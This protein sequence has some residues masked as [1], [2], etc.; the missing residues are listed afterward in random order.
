MQRGDDG[1]LGNGASYGDKKAPVPV[2]G[3]RAFIDM[4][5]GSYHTCALALDGSAWCWG[6]DM[7]NG[8]TYKTYSPEKV[9]GGHTFVA[10]SGGSSH[11]CAL[12]DA[13]QIWCWGEAG[14]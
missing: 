6:T 10:L 8:Q 9:D 13:A 3:G 7:K 4:A 1:L 2:S 11:T 12:D 14:M 5:L